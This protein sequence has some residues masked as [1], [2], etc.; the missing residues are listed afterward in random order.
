MKAKEA[1]L[2]VEVSVVRM[3]EVDVEKVRAVAESLGVLLR[4]REYIHCFF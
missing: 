3:P 4:V 2:E 1:G